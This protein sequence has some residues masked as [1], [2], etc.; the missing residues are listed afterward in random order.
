[1]KT[2]QNELQS[3]QPQ[4]KNVNLLEEV[5]GTSGVSGLLKS[6]AHPDFEDRHA[7]QLHKRRTVANLT[8]PPT[9]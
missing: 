7:Y 6:A 2:K 3:P 4:D 8:T 5:D 9:L 1:M